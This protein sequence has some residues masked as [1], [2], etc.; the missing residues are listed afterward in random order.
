MESLS[1]IEMLIREKVEVYRKTHEEVSYDLKRLYPSVRGLSAM[2]VRRFCNRHCIHKTA[3]LDV[4]SIDRIV[5]VNIMKVNT[6]HYINFCSPCTCTYILRYIH[7][8]CGSQATP[9]DHT[10]P[11]DHNVPHARFDFK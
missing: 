4:Y 3:R 9:R 11:R 10:V 6:N 8:G 5:S 2:S 7:E 1:G